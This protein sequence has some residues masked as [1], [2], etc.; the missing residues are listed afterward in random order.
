MFYYDFG[1]KLCLKIV[2]YLWHYMSINLSV[3][4]LISNMI[5]GSAAYTQYTISIL[6]FEPKSIYSVWLLNSDNS[7]HINVN[8]CYTWCQVLSLFLFL[9]VYC[10]CCSF[11]SFWHSSS[12][13]ARIKLQYD[14]KYR[15]YCVQWRIVG[16]I[17]LTTLPSSGQI[18]LCIFM[19][20][21]FFN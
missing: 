7:R 16:L 10:C 12:F 21:D 17:L 9:F 8:L 13:Q 4:I 2:V 18:M 11:H 1:N 15:P 3:I 20:P 5:N 19:N 14:F 6:L